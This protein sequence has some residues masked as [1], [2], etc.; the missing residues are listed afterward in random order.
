MLKDTYLL[1]LIPRKEGE[2][3]LFGLQREF[4]ILFIGTR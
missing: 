4:L 3:A 2:E 1:I